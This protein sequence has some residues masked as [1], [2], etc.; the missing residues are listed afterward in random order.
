MGF[1]QWASAKAGY[2][3]ASIYD[4]TAQ[5]FTTAWALT[6]GQAGRWPPWGSCANK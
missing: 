6:H 1:W 3:G 4:P 5:I 2:S